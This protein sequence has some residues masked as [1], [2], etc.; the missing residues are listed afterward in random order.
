MGHI[1][2]RRQ[3]SRKLLRDKLEIKHDCFLAIFGQLSRFFSGVKLVF[4]P[5]YRCLFVS[6]VLQLPQVDDFLFVFENDFSILNRLLAKNPN[7][8]NE[9]FPLPAAQIRVMKAT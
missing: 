8:V 2:A 7:E 9:E 1:F 4:I 3:L 5:I 6:G